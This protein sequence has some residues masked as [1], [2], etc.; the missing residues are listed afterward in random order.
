MLC[1][2]AYI[3]AAIYAKAVIKLKL[4]RNERKAD[5]VIGGCFV[6]CFTLFKQVYL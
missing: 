5:E 4:V 2:G 1:I 6:Y 3:E